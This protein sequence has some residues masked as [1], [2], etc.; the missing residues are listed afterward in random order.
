MLIVRVLRTHAI[1]VMRLTIHTAF[2]TIRSAI[3]LAAI[4]IL[5]H[6]RVEIG[7]TVIRVAVRMAAMA[8]L[9]VMRLLM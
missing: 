4:T 3:V 6:V 5:V 1:T 9:R 7:V 2:C 8:S